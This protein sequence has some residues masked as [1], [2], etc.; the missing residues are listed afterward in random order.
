MNFIALLKTRFPAL[1]YVSLFFS[2]ILS[3]YIISVNSVLI[4]ISELA[5]IS[6]FLIVFFSAFVLL[7]FI[8]FL[9]LFN[10]RIKNVST[11]ST[12]GKIKKNKSAKIDLNLHKIIYFIFSIFS[13]IALYLIRQN[14]II[15]IVVP[16]ILTA[17]Y[18]YLDNKYNKT[19]KIIKKTYKK[20]LTQGYFKKFQ[21]SISKINFKKI[22]EFFNINSLILL[23]LIS[24]LIFFILS[25]SLLKSMLPNLTLKIILFQSIIFSLFFI[26]PLLAKNEKKASGIFVVKPFIFTSLV[27]TLVLIASF[28]SLVKITS[29]ANANSII[30]SH[31]RFSEPV[32]RMDQQFLFGYLYFHKRV[33]YSIDNNSSGIFLF[34]IYHC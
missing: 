32:Y 4:I 26:L 7:Y 2:A 11:V 16:L 27:F 10:N 28:V 19:D 29:A 12:A 31:G 25:A 8:S 5:A 33:E 3:I 17:F 22:S 34:F 14:L 20:I 9:I 6:H 24:G 23:P 21:A 15:S 18:F 13:G 30:I 1:S